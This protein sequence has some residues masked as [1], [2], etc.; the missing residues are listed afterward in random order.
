MHALW[1][2]AKNHNVASFCQNDDIW[3][4]SVPMGKHKLDN[5][6]KEIIMWII[7]ETIIA[8]CQNGLL[9]QTFRVYNPSSV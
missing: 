7:K 9:S 6:L 8:K 2:K 5:L 1:Q 4:C 3:F